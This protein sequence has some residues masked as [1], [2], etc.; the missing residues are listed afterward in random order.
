[1]IIEGKRATLVNILQKKH[2]INTTSYNIY[3]KYH[4]NIGE[5]IFLL[6][7]LFKNLATAA[8]YLHFAQKYVH[9]CTN[10]VHN[11]KALK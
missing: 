1:M 8:V 4:R 9:I 11:Q 3:Q 7:C 10:T 2:I 5:L 6:L